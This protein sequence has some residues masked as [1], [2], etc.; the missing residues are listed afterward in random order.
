MPSTYHQCLKF[1]HNGQE[2]TIKGDPNPFQY[3]ST[4]KMSDYLVPYNHTGPSATTPI[5]PSDIAST[6]KSNGIKI[7]I[8]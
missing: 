7:D 8:K 3:C 2:I 1:P 5:N 6:S 4:V